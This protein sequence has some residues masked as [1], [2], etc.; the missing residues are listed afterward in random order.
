[1]LG[2]SHTTDVLGTGEVLL[3]FTSGRELVLKDVLHAPEIRKNL[4]S[5]FLLNKVG[6]KQVLEADQ[7]V[8]SK[9]GMFV[10]KGYA[11][12]GMFKLNVEM[13]ENNNSSAYIVSCVNVWH[14][15]LCHINN[16]YMKNMSYLGLIPKLEI[17]FEKCEICSMTKI[18][19]KSY[20][21]VERD[22]KLL[23][24]IHSD[25]C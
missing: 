17:E 22:S 14:G 7:F 23:E 20:K 6:F 5:G 13:N 19:R 11:C 3:K 16:K 12:D 25:I 4:V 10:G 2:D 18:T 8:L 21:S 1:M 24:L 15:R 9:K